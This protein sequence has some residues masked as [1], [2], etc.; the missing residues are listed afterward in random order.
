MAPD[1]GITVHAE[2]YLNPSYHRTT[3]GGGLFLQL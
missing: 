2:R 3:V 1:W